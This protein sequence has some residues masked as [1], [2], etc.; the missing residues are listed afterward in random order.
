V[1]LKTFRNK[2][3]IVLT[4]SDNGLGIDSGQINKLFGM[5]KRLHDH[6]EGSGIGL[7]IV[8]RNIEN[9]GGK[10]EVDSTLG[11]GTTFKVSFREKELARK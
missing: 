6:V 4:V 3:C 7:Y 5:F 2:N 1:V 10:I 11:K 9:A 8:K